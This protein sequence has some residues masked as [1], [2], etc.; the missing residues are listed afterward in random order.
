MVDLHV[1]FPMRLLG[2]VEAPGDV[3]R[4]MLRVRARQGSKLRAAVLALAARLFDPETAEQILGEN[5]LRVL[6]CRFR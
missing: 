6:E 3:V 2:E 4:G 1:H 5:A